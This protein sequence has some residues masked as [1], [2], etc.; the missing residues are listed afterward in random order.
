M[1]ERQRK[2]S[3]K[4]VPNTRVT[5]AGSTPPVS[6]VSPVSPTGGWGDR[7]LTPAE[8]GE[9]EG[10][11]A[12][13]MRGAPEHLLGAAT[14][15]AVEAWASEL[16]SICQGSELGDLDP[17][18]VFA[19]GLISYA[20]ARSSPGALAVLRSLAAVAPEPYRS[21]AGVAADRMA[22]EGVSEPAWATSVRHSAPTGAWLSH[23]PVHDD[24]VSV[25]VGFTGPA[26]HD[27]VG[28]YVDHNLGGVAKDA[29]VL[30][31]DIDEVVSALR[32]N[33]T[34][35]GVEFRPISLVEAASRWRHT[36]ALTDASVGVSVT[37][38]VH[39]LRA[40]IETRLAWLPTNAANLADVG[41]AT[42]VTHAGD[43]FGPDRDASVVSSFGI[44]GDWI[45]RVGVGGVGI[46]GDWDAVRRRDE[47]RGRLLAEFLRSDD[48]VALSG[49]VGGHDDRAAATVA[50]LASQVM[51]FSFDYV[52]GA[53]LRFSP[54][55]VEVF[56]L[57]WAP[58]RIAADPD[59]FAL[60][61]DVLVAWIRFA[62]RRR[63]IPDQSIGEAVTAARGQGEAMIDLAGDPASWGPAKLMAM[64][65]IERGIDV[66]DPAAVE[67]L[68]DDVN[69]SGGVDALAVLFGPADHLPF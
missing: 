55:M 43:P 45:D 49:P 33:A 46:D 68:V 62:G 15:L 16:W 7:G 36:L 5:S 40:L 14:P 30:A 23:D 53:P 54:V 31:A 56:C 3:K 1:A 60:L 59:A 65:I 67:A 47:R 35:S 48:A 51:A 32:A 13:I 10:V 9:L 34:A 61:T 2:R 21:R 18:V 64:T 37:P 29:F 26:G 19:G 17:E 57:D 6:P 12:S 28:L 4:N 8:Q 69:R 24:G 25:M 39:H 11:F 66:T 42:D 38:D 20:S 22:A 27:V 58:R 63:G 41:H 44:D 52:L 50:Y